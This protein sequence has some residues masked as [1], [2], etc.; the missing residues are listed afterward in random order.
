MINPI[1]G[2]NITLAKTIT[3]MT[4]AD[5]L[6]PIVALETVVVA[7]RTYQAYKRGKWDEARERFIEESLGSIVWLC[8]VKSLNKLGDKVVGK[9]LKSG[10]TNFDVGTDKILRTPFENFMKKQAPRNFSPNQVALIKGAKVMTSIILAN[11]FIGFIVP[12]LNQALTRKVRKERKAEDTNTKPANNINFKGAPGMGSIN[13]FTNWIENTNTGQLLSSDAG[14][15]GGRMYNARSK[16]ERREIAIRDIGS[17]YFYMWA[18]GHVRKGLNLIET[19]NSARLNPNAAET[20]NKHLVEFIG[21]REMS[22]EEFKKAILGEKVQLP[23]NLEKLTGW[24]KAPKNKSLEVIRLKELEGEI[25]DKAIWER[26]KDMSKLQPERLGEAVITK[27]QLQDAFNN[28]EINN[29][30]LLN[31]VFDDFTG[32][33]YKNEFKYVSNKKLYNLK[34][35]ME[36]YV[37]R[38][39]KSK[40][41]EKINKAVLQ[42]F[43]RKNLILSGIN[44]AAGFAVAAAFLSTY[45]PKFQ[46]W[47]TKK[48]T[49]VDAFPGVYDFEKK[50]EA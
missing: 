43:E 31:K 34:A 21:D 30:K 46:Y 35:E 40:K 17:I 27:Q 29:P 3:K 16:E 49:G 25:K 36:H 5:A 45:I 13:K 20:L 44:F 32:G 28:A 12:P 24:E 26:V 38:L 19:G 10:G 11:L 14:I 39:C 15:A 47:F 1:T 4:K 7:G 8:G 42:K 23:D 2:R 33:D 50:K 18:Q 6:A 9:I 48:T 37:E 41:N 22:S